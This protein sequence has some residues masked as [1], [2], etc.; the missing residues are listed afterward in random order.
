MGRLLLEN[1]TSDRLCYILCDD[2]TIRKGT[3]LAHTFPGPLMSSDR[4][5]VDEATK[6]GWKKVILQNGH[7]AWL[8]DE[9]L[10]FAPP[11]FSEVF[12]SPGDPDTE[13]T[14]GNDQEGENSEDY[15]VSEVD[16]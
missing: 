2:G 5:M 14:G 10:L 16:H 7:N 1:I 13:E 9:V 8:K 11:M 4:S 3:T 15:S 12:D 6:H